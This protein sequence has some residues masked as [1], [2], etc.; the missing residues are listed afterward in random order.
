MVCPHCRGSLGMDVVV[1]AEMPDERQRYKVARSLAALGP[2]VLGLSALREGLR[3]PDCAVVRGAT[4]AAADRILEVLTGE[5]ELQAVQRL[6]QT[7][8]AGRAGSATGGAWRSAKVLGLPAGPFWAGLVLVLAGSVLLVGLMRRGSRA[9]LGS[10]PRA[11]DLS[12]AAFQALAEK[13][14]PSRARVWGEGMRGG[15]GFFVAPELVLAL[16]HPVAP[17]E[18][19][20]AFL[21][22]QKASGPVLQADPQSGL[23]LV[24]L[25]GAGPRPLPLADAATVREG[26]TLVVV[27]SKPPGVKATRGIVT[28]AA[29]VR[30]GLTLIQLE[31]QLGAD[32]WGDTVLDTDGRV[33]GLVRYSDP[34]ARVA[35]VLPVNYAF[36]W[37]P[38]LAGYDK[39]EWG[40]RQGAAGQ[41]QLDR[42]QEF[43]S[44]LQHPVL[45]E[46]R[47][48]VEEHGK[49]GEILV[50]RFWVV[51]AAPVEARGQG[52]TYA[53]FQVGP[54][55]LRGSVYWWPEDMRGD[56]SGRSARQVAFERWVKSQNVRER[57]LVGHATAVLDRRQC[58]TEG[59]RELV[60]LYGGLPV[61]QLE[62]TD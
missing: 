48:G 50:E 1:T 14:S 4:R 36:P 3:R 29:F 5:L 26:D 47:G 46:A 43:A 33:V 6:S 34:G 58:P 62:I 54:C 60:L 55:E 57:T 32:P 8:P 40:G 59:S 45:I 49:A 21:R 30:D 20:A 44:V 51:L 38:S 35:M 28:H 31:A 61:S 52:T 13:A 56:G 23:V 10:R 53:Q 12:P 7:T 19:Q 2:P 25:P 16:A 11:A 24:S 17:K 18:A 9:S 27:E 41:A 42:D 37:L 39:S 15:A 22:T